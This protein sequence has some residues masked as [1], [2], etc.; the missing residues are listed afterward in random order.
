MAT[1][2]ITGAAGS[3][4]GMLR[5][6]LARPGRTLRLADLAAVAPTGAGEESVAADVT[7]PAAVAA[8][9]AGADAVVHLA[10]I[11][12]EGRWD[13]ILRINIDGTRNVLE[14]ARTAGVRRVILASSNHAVGFHTRAADPLPPDLH[15]RPDTYYGVA[16]AA[17]EA[18]GSLYVDRFGM[19][20]VA[21][22]IGSCFPEPFDVRSLATWLSPDDCGRLVEAAL[23]A[24]AGFGYREVWGV[25]AN[26][27]RWWSVDPD[28]DLG[29]APRDDAEEWAARLLPPGAEP[30]TTADPVL[31]R[32]G[33]AFCTLPLG[34]P[35]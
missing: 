6:R 23:T 8:A 21:L 4:G 22:R 20:V 25:S 9:C 33:G 31:Y 5:P 26:T 27:R 30:D 13:D 29:Y 35:A 14:A 1:I 3:V 17:M 24:P 12:T 15:P 34:E 11:A 32:V 18:L 19:D 7:D 28:R 16:K 10:G 2:L